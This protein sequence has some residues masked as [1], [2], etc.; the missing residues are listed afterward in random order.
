MYEEK[1]YKN[2]PLCTELLFL[3]AKHRKPLNKTF[4]IVLSVFVSMESVNSSLYTC[5]ALYNEH[6]A[7]ISTTLHALYSD[8]KRKI[9]LSSFYVSR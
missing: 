3:S 1:V 4:A 2:L 8:H 6:G 5:P 9:L 7:F